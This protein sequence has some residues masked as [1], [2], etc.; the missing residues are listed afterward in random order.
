MAAKML[1]RKRPPFVAQVRQNSCWAAAL[2]TWLR[3]ELGYGWSQNQIL[4]SAPDFSVGPAGIALNG[5]KQA[6]ADVTELLTVKMFTHII[7]R[8]QDIPQVANVI[9]EVGYVYLAFS[10]PN[11]SGGHVNVLYGF[12]GNSYTA[13]DPD[14]QI[15]EVTRSHG[16]YFTRFPALVG[17]RSTSGLI[18]LDSPN[19]KGPWDYL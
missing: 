2:E 10:R 17:W 5:L 15:G 12:S 16:F 4:N 13:I 6:I 3:A 11:G 7:E 19:G 8:P 1:F 18:G 9:S 14:P